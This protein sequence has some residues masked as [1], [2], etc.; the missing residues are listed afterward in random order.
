MCSAWDASVLPI[1]YAASADGSI[2]RRSDLVRLLCDVAVAARDAGFLPHQACGQADAFEEGSAYP[3][4]DSLA[5]AS[6]LAAAQIELNSHTLLASSPEI[7]PPLRF[8]DMFDTSAAP[9][10]LGPGSPSSSQ[11]W[12]DAD[13]SAV[14]RSIAD[15]LCC[16]ALRA[17]V[18]GRF[19]S[20]VF[21]ARVGA[22]SRACVNLRPLNSLLR[23]ST[24]AYPTARD[25]AAC[26]REW[27]IKI[28]LRA[29]F[30]RV[31]LPSCAR[32]WLAFALDGVDF[33]YDALPFGWSWSPEVFCS[34]LA[35]AIDAARLLLLGSAIVV[36]YVDDIAV[37]ADSPREVVEAAS[38][39]LRCLRDAGW[40]A[41]SEKTFLRPV[42]VLRFLGVRVRAGT[43]P[44][45]G[46]APSILA[47]AALEADGFRSLPC[48]RRVVVFWGLLSFAA[49]AVPWLALFRSFLDIPVSIIL[50]SESWVLDDA[51]VPQLRE[52]VDR[53]L[54][55]LRLAVAEG[56][57]PL[58][59]RFDRVF[60]IATDASAT[61]VGATLRGEHA[62]GARRWH[63][64]L[65]TVESLSSSAARE[66]V[67]L[68][69]ALLA[70][71]PWLSS[72]TV[73][74]TSDSTAATA[75]IRG[76]SSASSP[77]RHVLEEIWSAARAADITLLPVWHPREHWLLEEADALSRIDAPSGAVRH[78]PPLTRVVDA[79]RALRVSPSLH[80]SALPGFVAAREY[81]APLPLLPTRASKAPG[82]PRWLGPD[83]L[84]SWSGRAV[85]VSGSSPCFAELALRFWA[86]A[87][88]RPSALLVLAPAS[89][90][91]RSTPLASLA[92]LCLLSVHLVGKGDTLSKL[93]PGVGWLLEAA[94]GPWRA[95][96]FAG[97]PAS[98]GGRVR[99]LSAAEVEAFFGQ[100]GTP[101]HPG[102][103]GPSVEQQ[104]SFMAGRTDPTSAVRAAVLLRPLG[105]AAAG[106]SSALP[107]L[108]D[109][110]TAAQSPSVELAIGL[111]R[112]F[113]P[114][115]SI[116]DDQVAAAVAEIDGARASATLARATRA[117][118]SLLEFARSAGVDGASVCPASWDALATAW[119]RSR[120][121]SPG[122]LPFSFGARN[123][124]PPSPATV[125]ADVTAVGA[126]L[127]RRFVLFPPLMPAPPGLGPLCDAWL[128]AAGA[129]A[130]YDASPKRVC[131]GWEVRWGITNNPDVLLAHTPAVVCLATMGALMWRSLYVRSLRRC[132]AATFGAD[133]V[134]CR[135]A[136]PHKSN[137]FAGMQGVPSTAKL[138]FVAAP[139]LME[140][141]GPLVAAR[142]DASS[143]D[144]L[145]CDGIGQTLSYGY[146]THVLRLLLAGL[147]DAT[148]ATLHGLRVGC[149]AELRSL[150]VPD[151]VRDW[152]GWWRRVLRRVCELYEAISVESL[153]AAARLYGSLVAASLAPGLMSSTGEMVSDPLPIPSQPPDPVS[154]G[155]LMSTAS[156]AGSSR[157]RR[158]ASVVAAT[159]AAS[160]GSSGEALVEAALRCLP[161]L[162]GVRTRHCGLCGM[163]G[164]DRRTCKS[165]AA[166]VNG[167]TDDGSESDDSETE[168][169]AL[170][171]PC[172]PR[173]GPDPLPVAGARGPGASL[174]AALLPPAW[175]ATGSRGGSP[176]R[177]GPGSRGGD[178]PGG[179]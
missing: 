45:L 101:P 44:A 68:R 96:L 2:V 122:S 161:V 137:R 108:A 63:A 152:M 75:T 95:S 93:V 156:R 12:V 117:A 120:L 102:P 153:L 64:P 111:A 57:V 16:G 157:L 56:L 160:L 33:V 100:S 121:V 138:G 135:W 124:P 20:A 119:A 46:V 83:A 58:L 112:A 140:L 48:G 90:L 85:L 17:H 130:R 7:R 118:S 91:L 81:T 155:H 169:A 147:P 35:P 173:G 143:T 31:A 41:S 174:A 24:V 9:S 55:A 103:H 89:A 151:D 6:A 82:A 134:V 146:L 132:D 127:R 175:F 105:Q 87:A 38:T 167:A 133:A 177:F 25:L 8:S 88:Q 29:A 149:D 32:N 37:A 136:L 126:S 30:K 50:V 128:T 86:A 164:H 5:L 163:L 150:G 80:A 145:F 66:L 49:S 59:P 43:D 73:V 159:A 78:V 28:D 13:L 11:G 62:E 71:L 125:A 166:A 36:A 107:S 116:L 104:W 42:R 22:K 178:G 158:D 142:A 179:R 19:Q 172:V 61:G 98:L 97:G 18:R 52:F 92:R 34:A 168:F 3:A 70:W 39:L 176:A 84:T 1:V 15:D 131:W 129:R 123:N 23:P 170:Q 139:W 14:L 69:G 27:M 114:Q 72:S 113:L 99:A 79:C 40:R 76:W 141:L 106:G 77:C 47:K 94:K 171:V 54:A 162:R 67:A 109:A 10:A 51:A 115:P 4:T 26:G 148:V 110:L 65:S 154:A 165:V 60:Q 21:L 53:A 144:P 74:W